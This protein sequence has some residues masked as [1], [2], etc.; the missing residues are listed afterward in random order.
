M[1]DE[2]TTTQ[3]APAA[4]RRKLVGLKYIAHGEGWA[5]VPKGY[6]P[7]AEFRALPYKASELMA[8][9]WY[10]GDYEDGAEEGSS[11]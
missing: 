10:E 8:S 6:I 9:G 11:E 2:T 5:S 7:R 3:D 4:P 1:S